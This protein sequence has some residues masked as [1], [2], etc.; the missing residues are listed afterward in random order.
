MS[1]ALPPPTA[2]MALSTGTYGYLDEY[3]A[4]MTGLY[5]CRRVLSMVTATKN[6]PHVRLVNDPGQEAVL[7]GNHGLLTE[8]NYHA[9]KHY[10]YQ[11]QYLNRARCTRKSSL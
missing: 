5:C 8:C 1:N 11:L 4:P 10:F 2:S 6:G 3:I 7:M 9:C